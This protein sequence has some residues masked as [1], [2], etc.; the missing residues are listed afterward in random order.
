MKELLPLG[1]LGGAIYLFTQKDKKSATSVSTSPYFKDNG[2]WLCLGK[3][4]FEGFDLTKQVIKNTLLYEKLS[5]NLVPLKENGY[6][7]R[8]VAI[9]TL[10]QEFKNF[11]TVNPEISILDSF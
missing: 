9:K 2:Y 1:L 8:E 6:N 3:K 11:K 7:L 10:K 4:E 5:K